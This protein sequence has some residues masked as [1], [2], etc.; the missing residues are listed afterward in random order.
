MTDVDMWGEPIRLPQFEVARAPEPPRPRPQVIT[1]IDIVSG[2]ERCIH[3][4][5]PTQRTGSC[6]TCI[7][8]GSTTGCG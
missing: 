6:Y 1:T 5:G 8:C 4:Q 7:V 2:P 3:C